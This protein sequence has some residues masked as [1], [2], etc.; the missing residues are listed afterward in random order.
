MTITV[1]TI[2][3]ENGYTLAINCFLFFY[4]MTGLMTNLAFVKHL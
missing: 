3:L 2:F 4:D 1:Y